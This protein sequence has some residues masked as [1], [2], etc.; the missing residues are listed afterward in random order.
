MDSESYLRILKSLNENLNFN[1]KILHTDY[2]YALDKAIDKANFFEVKPLKIKC[3]FHFVKSIR[4]K[5]KKI[6]GNKKG[7]NKETFTIL[8]NIELI[9][10]IDLTNIEK[11]KKFLIDEIN[12]FGKYDELI[13]Y[14]KTF[15]FKKIVNIIIIQNLLRNIII[16]K[17]QWKNY[18]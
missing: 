2:E 15:W 17:K 16:I 1:P 7:L 4:E 3:F 8:N 12:N 18:I 9:C 11:Y 5:I 10:F 13:K 6:G 14:L